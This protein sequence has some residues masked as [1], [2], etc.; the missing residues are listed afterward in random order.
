MLRY[1]SLEAKSMFSAVKDSSFFGSFLQFCK[2]KKLN[3][4]A[5]NEILSQ[6]PSIGRSFKFLL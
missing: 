2:V 6:W 1:L 3:V 4:T 5:I